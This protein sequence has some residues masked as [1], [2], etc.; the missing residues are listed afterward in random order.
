MYKTK[1][2]S[3]IHGIGIVLKQLSRGETELI[4]INIKWSYRTTHNL[5][6]FISLFL[7]LLV[8]TVR[9]TSI[10]QQDKRDGGSMVCEAAQVGAACQWNIHLDVRTQGSTD[11]P[12]C[13]IYPGYC[14]T[15]L[16]KINIHNL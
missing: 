9:G 5:E 13:Y 16:Y 15:T 8:I 6:H 12:K 2:M 11:C 4:K 14:C 3:Y 10:L 7:A 1:Q